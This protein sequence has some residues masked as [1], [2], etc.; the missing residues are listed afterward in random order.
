M[1]EVSISLGTVLAICAAIVSISSA[2]KIIAKPGKDLE[3][4]LAKYEK[5][6]ANDKEHLEKLD[7]YVK[8]SKKMDALIARCLLLILDH[9]IHGNNIEG[10]KKL[11]EE[12]EIECLG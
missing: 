4:K 6:L 7:A 2:Y 8:D 1:N 3:E 12:I 11:K 5:L 10:L 9:E